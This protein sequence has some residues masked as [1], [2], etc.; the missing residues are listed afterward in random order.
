MD[1]INELREERERLKKRLDWLG[2]RSTGSDRIEARIRQID[3]EITYIE[4]KASSK[5]SDAS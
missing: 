2:V 3:A 1:R 5:R 4:S